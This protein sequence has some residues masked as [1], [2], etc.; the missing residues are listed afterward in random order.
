MGAV[1][2]LCHS[3]KVMYLGQVVESAATEKLFDEPLHPYTKGLLA[4]IPHLNVE[5]GKNLP[6]IT[7]TV[8]PLSKIPEGCHFCTRCMDKKDRC[9]KQQPPLI[10][11]NPGHFVKCWK[12]AAD[13]R[14]EREV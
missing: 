14:Q 1:A 7:G 2:Q 5:R 4:C 12:Y 10:E 3:V 9:E 11:V 8:P 13:E 6:V